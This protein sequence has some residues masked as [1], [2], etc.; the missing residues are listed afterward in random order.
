MTSS[1]ERLS[2]VSRLA[3]LLTDQVPDAQIMSRP[4]L[5]Q[6]IRALLDAALLLAEYDVPLPHLLTQ[7]VYEI[8]SKTGPMVE[9]DAVEQA[10]AKGMAWLLRPFQGRKGP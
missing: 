2:E 1:P 3:G 6:H 8:D 7:I 5:D 9:T 10:G 4:I